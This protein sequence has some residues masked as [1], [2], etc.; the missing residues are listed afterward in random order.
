M[1]DNMQYMP[2]QKSTQPP[3]RGP[4]GGRRRASHSMES[5][6]TEAVK[7]L[8]E[9]G[10]STLTFRSLASRLGGGVGSIYWYVSGKEEL[11]ERAADHVMAQVLRDTEQF[12]DG[13]AIEDLRGTAVAL[14]EA[15]AD[16]PW[17][18]S[19]FMRSAALRPSSL[20]YFERVGQ[21]MMRLGLDP[22]ASFNAAS[23]VV[24]YVIGIAADLGHQPPEEVV[25]RTVTREEYFARTV[26]DWRD[27]D[28]EEWPF[29]HSIVDVFATHDDTEQF[30]AGL[31]LILAGLRIQA[32]S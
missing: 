7:L 26:G 5:V 14:F 25:D 6:I 30:L 23:A 21:H 17:L 28:P 22:L 3:H 11:I 31:D 18:G 27:L 20:R 29:L 13:D 15:V 1:F 24:G 4:H 9:A 12:E 16:R 10:D 19:Y 8:D 32:G 2:P